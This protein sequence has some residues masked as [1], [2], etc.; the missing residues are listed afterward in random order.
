MTLQATRTIG[1]GDG[2][3]RTDSGIYLPDWADLE[4][5]EADVASPPLAIDLFAGAGGFSLGFKQAGWHVIAANECDADAA[6]TYLCNL[7]S[8]RTRIVFC[9][10][11]DEERWQRRRKHL[12][13]YHAQPG[14][15][16]LEPGS[17]WIATESV[18]LPP[19]GRSSATVVEIPEALAMVPFGVTTSAPAS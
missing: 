17:G 15:P 1:T 19:R 14:R 6:H 11:E 8:P 13:R 18:P 3:E 5:R 9:T 2:W 16:S 10:P 4:P 12:G 7:G